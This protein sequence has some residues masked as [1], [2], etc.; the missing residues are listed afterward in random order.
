MAVE[1]MFGVWGIASL[2]KT[3]IRGSVLL[4]YFLFKVLKRF[5]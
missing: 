2:Q 4:D 5:G 3:H 1:P